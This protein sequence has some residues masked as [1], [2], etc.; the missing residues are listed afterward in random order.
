MT[1]EAEVGVFIQPILSRNVNSN[2][3]DPFSPFNL[4]ISS[5]DKRVLEKNSVS[6]HDI[7]VKK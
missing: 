5:G 1:E 3:T 6:T 2:L 7:F 4:G